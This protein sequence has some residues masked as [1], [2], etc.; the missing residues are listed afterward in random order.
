MEAVYGGE[1]STINYLQ[2][3]NLKKNDHNATDLTLKQQD[4]HL[5]DPGRKTPV[6]K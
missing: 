5:Y 4:W 2:V 1:E 3:Y 6:I